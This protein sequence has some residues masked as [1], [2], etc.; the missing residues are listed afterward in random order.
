MSGTRLIIRRDLASWATRS[1][2]RWPPDL[3]GAA[4]PGRR[5]RCIGRIAADGRTA[6]PCSRLAGTAAGRHRRHHPRLQITRRKGPPS[7]SRNLQSSQ[8]ATSGRCCPTA[9]R[10]GVPCR[11]LRD[12]A[13][14][15]GDTGIPPRS[16]Q[17][18]LERWFRQ[19]PDN[20]EPRAPGHPRIG[21]VPGRWRQ[22]AGHPRPPG[23]STSV[24]PP[25][26]PASPP[27]CI[28]AFCRLKDQRIPC[29]APASVQP[30]GS[31][32]LLLGGTARARLRARRHGT[33]PERP[34]P[35]NGPMKIRW[36]GQWVGAGRATGAQ[37]ALLRAAKA[38]QEA[39]VPISFFLGPVRVQVR[40][41][42][43]PF[44]R[45]EKRPLPISE[46][47]ALEITKKPR[48]DYHSYILELTA[49]GVLRIPEGSFSPA[50]ILAS[51]RS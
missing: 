37:P 35:L 22:G 14:P 11:A 47:D 39:V 32:C 41:H 26:P 2:R 8:P 49:F 19:S 20:T 25:S 27:E 6:N 40:V 48:N 18:L 34:L 24:P 10:F 12:Q 46:E 4:L 21:R 42:R 23:R 38:G 29:H 36:V 51:W 44:V 45:P 28:H 15:G 33:W 7:L 3:A 13:Q 31:S 1:G 5:T 50:D 43:P 30:A 16:R 17:P 9:N